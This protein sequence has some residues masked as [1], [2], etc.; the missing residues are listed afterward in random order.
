MHIELT[1]M[2]VLNASN[3]AVALLQNRAALEKIPDMAVGGAQTLWEQVEYSMEVL[4]KI[5]AL[6]V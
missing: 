2:D 3:L 6:D 4:E 5:A 1:E